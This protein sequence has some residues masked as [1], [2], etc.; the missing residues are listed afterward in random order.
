MPVLFMNIIAWS[1]VLLVYIF[2]KYNDRGIKIIAYYE[3]SHLFDKW[4]V[5]SF[6]FGACLAVLFGLFFLYLFIIDEFS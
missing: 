6:S 4:W 1:L 3:Q 5:Y 2:Y